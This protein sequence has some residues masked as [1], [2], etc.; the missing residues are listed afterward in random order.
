MFYFQFMISLFFTVVKF[1]DKIIEIKQTKEKKVDQ[2]KYQRKC[3]MSDM[4]MET[5]TFNTEY[6]IYI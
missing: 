5:L 1:E 4:K 6:V 3:V 2:Q